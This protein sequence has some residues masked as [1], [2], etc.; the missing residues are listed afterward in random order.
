MSTD[1]VLSRGCRHN[2]WWSMPQTSVEFCRSCGFSLIY[3]ASRPSKDVYAEVQVQPRPQDTFDPARVTP[4]GARGYQ[5]QP[6]DLTSG[7]QIRVL[8]LKAGR[9]ED[10]LQC[11]LEH[12]NLQQGP[13]YEA[14]SYTWADDKGDDSISRAIQ[15][16]YDGQFIGI[17]KNCELALLRLRKQDVDRRLWVDA[18]CIDQSNILERNHQ[19]KNMIAIFRSAIRVV[20]FLDRKIF[21]KALVL[22]GSASR[23]TDSN[24]SDPHVPSPSSIHDNIHWLL[25]PSQNPGTRRCDGRLDFW[26]RILSLYHGATPSSDFKADDTVFRADIPPAFGGFCSNCFEMDQMHWQRI[27]RA[28]KLDV[29]QATEQATK[30]AMASWDTANWVSENTIS[31]TTKD[32]IEKVLEQATKAAAGE[33]IRQV[34]IDSNWVTW[35]NKMAISK[36][37]HQS[38]KE[39]IERAMTM[40]NQAFPDRAIQQATDQH[41]EVVEE[42]VN[43]TIEQANKKVTCCCMSQ[44]SSPGHFD[45][46]ELDSFITNMSQY[47]MGRRIFA[48]D[49]SEAERTPQALGGEALPWSVRAAKES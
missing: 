37:I 3:A 30:Q 40:T 29:N 46:D 47:G 15:C 44:S 32:T 21:G 10:P 11:E 13:I 45:K 25:N 1:L 36:S 34:T 38:I 12:V 7:R 33:A 35:A 31:Q 9:L 43:R 18:V 28:M 6:L 48:I 17:T 23:A 42:A 24:K 49:L 20:V 8:V 41:A 5:Y 26:G 22:S 4:P 14:L 19:V 27:K 2:D 16:G 39:A